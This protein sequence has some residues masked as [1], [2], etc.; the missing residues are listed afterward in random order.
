MADGQTHVKLRAEGLLPARHFIPHISHWIF[1][2]NKK[3]ISH[4]LFL[5]SLKIKLREV[6]YLTPITYLH[7]LHAFLQFTFLIIASK[8]IYVRDEGT[9]TQ[10][11]SPKSHSM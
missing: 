7:S 6:I 9:D 3:C 8:N 11:A 1:L 5:F 10:M 2:I 4:R